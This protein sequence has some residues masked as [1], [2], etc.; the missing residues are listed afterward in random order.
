MVLVGGGQV[1]WIPEFPFHFVF[2]DEVLDDRFKVAKHFKLR[3][4]GFG[5]WL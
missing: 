2:G 4:E 1:G 5:N 3:S